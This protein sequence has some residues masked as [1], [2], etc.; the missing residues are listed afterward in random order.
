MTPYLANDAGGFEE[1]SAEEE[2]GIFALDVDAC[3]SSS[4]I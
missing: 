3:F 1:A 2:E 4:S